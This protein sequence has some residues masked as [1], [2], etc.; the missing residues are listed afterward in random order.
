M[1]N[2]TKNPDF[3]KAKEGDE[4]WMYG[5]GETVIDSNCKC[6]TE[7]EESND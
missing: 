3:S 6:D 7:K 4:C 1:S 2:K 5:I